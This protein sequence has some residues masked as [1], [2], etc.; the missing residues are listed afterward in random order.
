MFGGQKAT[1]TAPQGRGQIILALLTLW[2]SAVC[3]GF[4][5]CRQHRCGLVNHPGS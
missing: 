2:V 4:Q 5:G 1:W 3:R